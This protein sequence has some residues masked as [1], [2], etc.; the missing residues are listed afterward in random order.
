[1][2]ANHHL[3]LSLSTIITLI[4][5]FIT[6]SNLQVD[7]TFSKVQDITNVELPELKIRP[8]WPSQELEKRLLVFVNRPEKVKEVDVAEK[9][10]TADGKAVISEVKAVDKTVKPMF[11]VLDDDHQVGLLAI[12]QKNNEKYAVLQK[13]HFASRSSENTRVKDKQAYAGAKV[14]IENQSTVVLDFPDRKIKLHL[15]KPRNS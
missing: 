8:S 5:I 4:L 1:M 10:S 13:I 3:Q 2:K 6:R 9:A 12:M 11:S 7:D 14:S 15:F